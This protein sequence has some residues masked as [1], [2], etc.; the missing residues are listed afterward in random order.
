MSSYPRGQA[1]A[2]NDDDEGDDD[3][4]S[5]AEG[6]R[7]SGTSATAAEAANE[8]IELAADGQSQQQQQQQQQIRKRLHTN[9]ARGAFHRTGSS[10]NPVPEAGIGS[11]FTNIAELTKD[12]LDMRDASN[13]TDAETTNTESFIVSLFKSKSLKGMKGRGSTEMRY[14]E[15]KRIGARQEEKKRMERTWGERVMEGVEEEDPK[16]GMHNSNSKNDSSTLMGASSGRTLS[17]R[18]RAECDENNDTNSFYARKQGVFVLSPL[19]SFMRKWDFLIICALLWTAVVTP[20]EVAFSRPNLNALFVLNRI[21]DL[22]FITDLFINFFLAVPEP[23]TGHI[24]YDRRY[25][26]ISY[27]RSWFII[28]FLSV[29]PTDLITI[30]VEDAYP[31]AN[32]ENLTVLRALRLFRL[33]KLLRI[34]RT[35]RLFKRLEMRYTIDYSMLALSKFAIVTVIFAHWMACAFGFVH[36]LGASAGHDTWMMN[37]YFGDF[38]VNNSC[39]D[40]TDPLAC[41]PG[42]DKYIAAL[43]WSSMTITT[44]GYGD[45][46]PKTNEERIFVII[47][48]LAG[49]F[50]YGYVVGAVGNVISTKNSRTS[51][52]KNSLTDLNEL[53]A[54]LPLTPQEMRV[55]LREFFK[56]KHGD[57]KLDLERTTALMSEMSPRLRAELVVLRNN[58]M[59]DVKFFHDFPESLVL[60]LSLKMK[61]QTYP[62]KELI[63]EKG[64]YMDNFLMIRKGVL[65]ANGRII[66]AGQV[67]G[68]DYVLEPGRSPQFLQTITFS[69]VYSLSYQDLEEEVKHYP[70]VQVMLKK[71][72]MQALLRREMVAYSK[73]YNALMLYGIK[74]DVYKWYDE[75]PQFYLNKLKT[76]NGADGAFLINPDSEDA[77]KRMRAVLLIQSCYRSKQ[78]R[79]KFK[80]ISARASVTP[81]LSSTLRLTNPDLYSSHAIDI[82]HHRTLASLRMLHH[83]ID[84]I[85]P[86]P[87]P[88]KMMSNDQVKVKLT[89][90]FEKQK[91]EF[92]TTPMPKE[93]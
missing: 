65:V 8:D 36:D 84:S 68:Q 25:I 83:K 75:R 78:T 21:V 86:S 23:K 16:A 13:K 87:P 60:A 66:T 38:T 14:A 46:S 77:Q 64:D 69:D 93:T 48:M 41:V 30:M 52:L 28:D 89:Q 71:K 59:R 5:S 73:A 15:T 63:L 42:F 39:Y 1:P 55:K 61:Q 72:R 9:D 53:F 58:W 47:A 51:G 40:P 81:V 50:Q 26:A 62:P 12:V 11:F 19:G 29:I 7:E 90:D 18:I 56:Y 24:I 74:S 91:G 27:L 82:L 54:D 44:I 17:S 20:A 85:M 80:N 57:A 10:L 37:T 79:E 45:I 6:R 3:W 2:M 34:L 35:M 33:A 67:F 43:Y 88:T 70:D 4:S 31:N 76:I 49:A 22:F 92:W 32:I